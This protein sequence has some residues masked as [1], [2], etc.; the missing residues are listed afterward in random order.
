MPFFRVLKL[1]FINLGEIG[2]IF[3]LSAFLTAFIAI[4]LPFCLG[5]LITLFILLSLAGLGIFLFIKKMIF[6]KRWVV[7]FFIFLYLNFSIGSFW[8]GKRLECACSQDN[9]F[10]ESKAL[11]GEK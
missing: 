7:W 11:N 2:T 10:C 3:L 8:T 6:Q 5:S 4:S 9:K 1:F